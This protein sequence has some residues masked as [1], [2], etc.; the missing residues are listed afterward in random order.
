[1]NINSYLRETSAKLIVK[2]DEKEKIQKS[3]NAFIDHI[4][5]YFTHQEYFRIL[6][7][8]VFGSYSRDTNLPRSIDEDSDVDIMVVFEKDGSTPQTYLNRIKRA[9]EYWYQ[10][11]EIKQSSPTIVLDMNHI[12]FEITPAVFEYGMYYIKNNDR[13]MPTHALEDFNYLSLANKNNKFDIKPIIRLIK[14]WNVNIDKKYCSSYEIEKAI[15]DYFLSGVYS[16]YDFKNK[17]LIAFESII[18]LDK[19]DVPKAI[20]N[21]KEAIS[22]ETKY[23]SCAEDEIMKVIE[24]I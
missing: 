19:I 6:D 13:W 7:V 18:H 8:I 22:D 15:V 1:M 23:P 12:K 4:K 2:D 14:Y 24:K 17:L 10:S 5:H 9:V 20:R 21:L 16:S 3:I 11:S